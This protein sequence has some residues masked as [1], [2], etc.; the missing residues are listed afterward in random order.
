[1]ADIVSDTIPMDTTLDESFTLPFYFVAKMDI[2]I[3]KC[4]TN[5]EGVQ[6]LQQKYEFMKYF[7]DIS[8]IHNIAN[9]NTKT[10]INEIGI[11]KHIELN[12]PSI[13]NMYPQVIRNYLDYLI[14]IFKLEL[15]GINYEIEMIYYRMN[16]PTYFTPEFINHKFKINE[17][18]EIPLMLSIINYDIMTMTTFSK[19]CDLTPLIFDEKFYNQDCSYLDIS[20]P[21][22][23]FVKTI[24]YPFQMDNVN[25]L[26]TIISEKPFIYL[27]PSKV[28]EKYGLFIKYYFH[29]E[30]LSEPEYLEKKYTKDIT[31]FSLK[32][33]IR[34]GFICDEPGLGKTIQSLICWDAYFMRYPEATCA[35]FV[36][37]HLISHWNIEIQK[38][39]KMPNLPNLNVVNIYESIEYIVANKPKFIIV[40][41][42]HELFT[43]TTKNDLILKK[44]CCYMAD[45]KIGLTATPFLNDN[46]LKYMIDFLVCDLQNSYQAI[47]MDYIT[48]QFSKYIIHKSKANIVD[49]IALPEININNVLIYMSAEERAV[50][51]AN[52]EGNSNKADLL[53]IACDKMLALSEVSATEVNM[54]NQQFREIT[55]KKMQ[56]DYDNAIEFVSYKKR[57][58]QDIISKYSGDIAKI[59]LVCEDARSISYLMEEIATGEKKVESKKIIM[60]RYQ[61]IIRNIDTIMTKFSKKP[62]DESTTLASDVSQTTEIIPNMEDTNCII[63]CD[64]YTD[65]GI[66]I[67][68]K[69][70]HYICM[71]CYHIMKKTTGCVCPTCRTD[72]LEIGDIQ[73]INNMNITSVGSK[74]RET[75]KILLA[76]KMKDEKFIIYTQYDKLMK[77]LLN[78]FHHCNINILSISDIIGCDFK[79]LSFDAILLSSKRNA[80]GLD[81]TIANNV[82]IIDP[83]Q[84]YTYCKQIEKQLIGRVHRIGQTKKV[85]VFRLIM[86]DTV[87]ETSY[88]Q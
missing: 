16:N 46:C 22:T 67:F 18:T 85:N 30:T 27:E 40:D 73:I 64:E 34:G 17:E 78:I 65:A 23:Q 60:A 58:M 19:Y 82:I 26:L 71:S 39:F 74:I 77:R 13:E 72:H 7:Q 3:V 38:H 70:G 14:S 45:V 87:E 56:T 50:Y 75:I 35:V 41:E 81:L 20:I 54:T 9:D 28:F 61:E 84:N 32:K 80:S 83:F 79:T 88:S 86:K 11:V 69:C 5:P 8:N 76:G 47:H 31:K 68:K 59:P 52:A 49:Y 1:M 21:Q 51:L 25:Q 53:E 37:E 36:P 10:F 43:I 55:I 66:A 24:P 4:K 63:C 29:D 44:L 62:I 15:N 2:N 42:I 6:S 12:K 33:Q 57:K 48:K